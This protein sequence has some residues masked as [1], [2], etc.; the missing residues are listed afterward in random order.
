MRRGDRPGQ[1][2]PVG[3]VHAALVAA[4]LLCGCTL[5]PDY[6]RPTLTVP[7][8]F[9]A[10]AD[11]G[12]ASASAADSAWWQQFG[13]AQLDA[14]IDEALAGNQDV[15]AAAARVD[16]FYGALG[17]TRAQL[18]PQLGADVSGARTRASGQTISP[19][20]GANPYNAFQ[21][22][23]LAS[24]EIDLFGRTRRLTEAAAAE[25]NASEAARRATVLSV[26][27]AVIAGYVRLRDLDREVEVARSTV[28][29]RE[30]TLRLF[31]RRRQGGVVSDLEVNQASSEYAS[32]LRT[33]RQLEQQAVQQENALSVLVG[34]NPGPIARG[35]AIQALRMPPVPFGLPSQVIERRPDLLA[36]EQQLVAANARIGAAKAAYFPSISLTGAFGSASRSLSDLWS[37]SARTWTYGADISLPIFTAGAI[38]GQVQSAEA[39]QRVSV[40]NYRQA[41]QTAF[42]E[43]DD[44]LTGV[45]QTQLAR[46]AAQ[47]QT[48]ALANYA[49]LARKRYDGGYTSYLEVLDAE[50]SLF[51]AQLQLSQSQADV[52]LQATQLYKSIGGGW[53]DLAGQKAPEP[54]SSAR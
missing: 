32:A 14:L 9:R 31:Q 24:W 54:L 6:A 52:L 21:A 40:A 25:L 13:D 49:R 26:V 29:L 43:T 50:R 28:G 12:A 38:A 53:V 3:A 8:R 41:V 27:A 18:F 51:N 44:A 23:L 30:D 36:A 15:V 20:P 1:R 45:R 5:G 39:A 19:A 16:Q 17:T 33:Q 11:A 10:A 2:R 4:L 48:E 47:Q 7:D 22:S 37:G 34:R 42:R 35:L 46:D